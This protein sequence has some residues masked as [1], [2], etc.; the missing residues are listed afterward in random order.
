MHRDIKP[1]NIFL[2]K[3]GGPLLIDFGAARQALGEHSKSLS[4]IIVSMG[5]APPEQYTSRGKQGPFTDL[6]AVGAVIYKIITGITPVESL[7]RSHAI[8]GNEKDPLAPIKVAGQGK[9]SDWLLEITDQLLN[10]SPKYRPQSAQKVLYAIQHK[11]PV[12]MNGGLSTRVYATNNNDKTQVVKEGARFTKKPVTT[13]FALT[14]PPILRNKIAMIVVS[15]TVVFGVA[16]G[17]W[18]YSENSAQVAHN[19]KSDIKSIQKLNAKQ[20]VKYDAILYVNSIPEGATVFI[21]N[22]EIGVTPYKATNLPTGKRQL[23]LS[24]KDFKD[25]ISD[26]NLQSNIIVKKNY[27]LMPVSGTL[28]IFSQPAGARIYIDGV[29]MQQTTPAT[30][31]NIQA[32]EH[33]LKLHKDKYYDLTAMVQ[34]KKD[35]TLRKEYRLKGGDLISYKGKWITPNEMKKMQVKAKK[36]TEVKLA[37]KKLELKRQQDKIDS[38]ARVAIAKEEKERKKEIEKQNKAKALA[39]QYIS[40]AEKAAK[41]YNF[42]QADEYLR[43][44]IAVEPMHQKIAVTQQKI[45]DFKNKKRQED[46]EAE[47]R[48]VTELR[49]QQENK[50]EVS[51]LP[52][53]SFGGF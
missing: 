25:E 26:V 33:K 52:R 3:V 14:N 23:K 5:Y 24:Y 46:A 2:R 19:I 53:R 12:E 27:P 11:M 49:L 40:L 36:R 22:K 21:N 44:L 34:V 8:N 1:G 18:W 20:P 47:L 31:L 48:K 13:T 41:Q 45:F 43:K 35:T 37:Q 10:I 15:V 28:N 16:V 32:G 39:K 38:A 17:G 7:E 4:A 42:D 29:D 6:Y 50:K 9:V 51:S 30:L